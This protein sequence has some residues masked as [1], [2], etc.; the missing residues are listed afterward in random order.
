MFSAYHA[1]FIAS[2]YLFFLDKSSWNVVSFYVYIYTSAT[3]TSL[4]QVTP[5]NRSQR[6]RW[7]YLCRNLPLVPHLTLL[8][9]SL[10]LLPKHF[11]M[12]YLSHAC[13]LLE[14]IMD[15]MKR[16]QS[17]LLYWLNN[18]YFASTDCSFCLLFLLCLMFCGY[19]CI[20][21]TFFSENLIQGLI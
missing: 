1:S 3:P 17:Q 8:S 11:N 9:C 7:A 18:N 16:K 14:L 2:F 10:L 20:F 4:S 15:M 6:K 19:I 12:W 21:I 13:N 5:L